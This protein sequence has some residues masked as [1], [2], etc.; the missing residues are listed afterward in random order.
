MVILPPVTHYLK[1]LFQGLADLAYPRQCLAC[2]NPPQE[3]K[4]LCL[5]SGCYAGFELLAAPYCQ[6]CARPL[7]LFLKPVARCR[8]CRNLS[9]H[10][11]RAFAVMEYEGV[12]KDILL[13]YKFHRRRDAAKVLAGLLAV[14]I[15]NEIPQDIQEA[16]DGFVIVP[17]HKKLPYG[18]TGSL[19]EN[20]DPGKIFERYAAAER[21]P[22]AAI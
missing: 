8:A 5:C 2:A 10:F 20:H 11:K 4:E 19:R 17:T 7:G 6:K 16:L 1:N 21:I 15:Q 3:N 9:A 12:M 13:N 22:G 18:F 14:C